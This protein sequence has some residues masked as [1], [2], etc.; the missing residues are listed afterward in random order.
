MAVTKAEL[1]DVG[2]GKGLNVGVNGL[3]QVGGQ[4]GGGAG[5][6]AAGGGAEDPTLFEEK[7]QRAAPQSLSL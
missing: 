5:G 3:P 2:K 6:K 4:A 1:V 7:G